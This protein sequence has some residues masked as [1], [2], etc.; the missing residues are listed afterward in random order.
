MAFV[1]VR[2]GRA[3]HSLE[4]LPCGAEPGTA[5]DY[6]GNGSEHVVDTFWTGSRLTASA[7]GGATGDGGREWTGAE[8]RFCSHHRDVGAG[9]LSELLG[10]PSAEVIRHMDSLGVDVP[11]VPLLGSVCPWCGRR[12]PVAGE[13]ALSGLCDACH[14]RLMTSLR[15]TA[16]A[17]RRA[18]RVSSRV[19]SS[20]W[21]ARGSDG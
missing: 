2:G 18:R 10:I 14:A 3:R 12:M 7:I 1:I 8:E 13:G 19:A 5:G 11:P 15:E 20:D 21:R 9:A 17:E 6:D 4:G 16:A